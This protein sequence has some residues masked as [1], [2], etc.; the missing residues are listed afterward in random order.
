MPE[1]VQNDMQITLVELYND[2]NRKSGPV[3]E[4]ET[5]SESGDDDRRMG[6][7]F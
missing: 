2:E 4:L 5:L 7:A 3:I 1:T 6:H